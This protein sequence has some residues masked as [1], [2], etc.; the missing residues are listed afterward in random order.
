M[1]DTNNM[2]LKPTKDKEMKNLNYLKFAIC[3][4]FCVFALA[5]AAQAQEQKQVSTKTLLR[6]MVDR[7]QLAEFPDPP[8]TCKQFSSYDRN[9]TTQWD[10]DTWFANQDHGNYLRLEE[11]FG[12]TE[13]VMMDAKGPGTVVRIWSANPSGTLRI[14]IDGSIEPTLEVPMK[15]FLTGGAGSVAAPLSAIKARGAN[16]YLPIPYAKQC[17][18]TC[19][20][21]KM[22]YYQINY[23]TYPDG[24]SVESFNANTI[25]D[26]AEL[27]KQTN[28]IL[29]TQPT[30]T[31][32][33]TSINSTINPGETAELFQ[34]DSMGAIDTIQLTLKH[35]DMDNALRKCILKGEFDNN[36]TI[37]CP[38]GDFFG[39]AP[40]LNAYTSRMLSISKSGLLTS[41]W[42]MPFKNKATFSVTNLSDKP[43]TISGFTKIAPYKWNDRS[44]HFNAVWRTEGPIPTKPRRDWN[45]A[46][47]Y[48]KGVWV[49]DALSIANPDKVWWGEGDEKIY[50]DNE[51]FPS[52]FGTGTE[53][54]YGY[55]WSSTVL[56]E[57]PFHNQTRCD[58]PGTFGFTSLNR[59]RYLDA[60]P[61]Y[62]SLKFDMEIW[63]W[64]SV[65]VHYA[66]TSYFYAMPG[67]KNNV[68]SAESSDLLAIP[69]LHLDIF[70]RKGAVEAEKLE[71]L[72]K[73]KTS[74][75]EVQRRG[76]GA[77]GTW[78][79]LNHLLCKSTKHGD[80]VDL[81]VP[82][83]KKGMREVIVYPTLSWDYG[84]LQF[85][86]NGQKAGEPIDTYNVENPDRITIPSPH[87]LGTYNLP[88]SSFTLRIEVVATHPKSIA[89]HYYWGLDC[90]VVK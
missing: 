78:S 71:V 53:D 24:T 32:S 10:E 45:Y 30:S 41:K 49:G 15:E 68:P 69:S 76:N 59:F 89:P 18:I 28:S 2:L 27:I 87:S 52:H 3:T 80:W 55:G 35:D 37:N 33:Q 36:Q 38:I 4:A 20:N 54:Y 58:G 64:K 61:F 74:I 26:N 14:Y 25:A 46:T 83:T 90:I 17:I 81:K 73:T 8:Y 79:D 62:E 34:V 60:I 43:I 5:F 51:K 65:G 63:H 40:G 50:V 21:S 31:H 16:L 23:R 29:Q 22:F 9:S 82:V 57:S 13:A 1:T 56:F 77:E 11:H 47:I 44:M 85:Y 66:A 84:I 19:K 48:G 67:T 72:A 39:S 70:R 6:E 86:I 88:D 7:T 42:I 12:R 75:L